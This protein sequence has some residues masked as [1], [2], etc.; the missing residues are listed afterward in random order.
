VFASF[1]RSRTE[2]DRWRRP[3]LAALAVLALVFLVALG[4]S[5]SL[6]HVGGPSRVVGTTVVPDDV[7]LFSIGL[8]VALG[9]IAVLVS[10][11]LHVWRERRRDDPELQWVYERPPAEWWEKLLG[12]LLA[13]ALIGGIVAAFFFVIQGGHSAPIRPRAVMPTAAGHLPPGGR[14]APTPH[15]GHIAVL[16]LGLLA[17]AV[18]ALAVYVVLLRRR[19]PAGADEPRAVPDD[20]EEVRVVID[21]SLDELE[22]EP[23]PRR[24]VIRAYVGMERVLAVRGIGRQPFE[25]PLEYLSRALQ[26]M[27][28]SRAAAERLTSLFQRARFSQHATGPEM[29]RQAIAALAEVR[30]E[31]RAAT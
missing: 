12:F 2:A 11:V 26:G 22:R 17:V 5:R 14:Q 30:D 6:A 4:S 10:L 8:I 7:T 9:S 24:A 25:A 21:E 31:L 13:L 1:G 20:R 3:A 27:R 29:K 23:D 28:V 18:L 16:S 19:R 15:P